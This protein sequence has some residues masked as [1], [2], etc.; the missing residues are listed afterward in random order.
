VAPPDAMS[1]HT[2]PKAASRISRFNRNLMFE[3]RAENRAVAVAMDQLRDHGFDPE[4]AVDVGGMVREFN[5]MMMGAQGAEPD[6]EEPLA[7]EDIVGDKA[8]AKEG[9]SDEEMASERETDEEEEEEEEGTSDKESCGSEDDERASLQHGSEAAADDEDKAEAMQE[10]A[11]SI[12]GAAEARLHY[13]MGSSAAVDSVMATQWGSHAGQD[14]DDI[15]CFPS[16]AAK[17]TIKTATLTITT[18]GLDVIISKSG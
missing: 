11:A 3:K 7:I 13:T 10:A 2:T 9:V 5:A 6:V 4:T 16:R 1:D 14:C 8:M 15:Q 12:D 18:Q 17:T